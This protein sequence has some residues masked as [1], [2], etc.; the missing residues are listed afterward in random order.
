MPLRLL[1]AAKIEQDASSR[2]CSRRTQFFLIHFLETCDGLSLT[3]HFLSLFL[4]LFISLFLSLFLS[5]SIFRGCSPPSLRQGAKSVM[6]RPQTRD[7]TPSIRHE[8]RAEAVQNFCTEECSFSFPKALV[9]APHAAR[10]AL[11]R[12]LA[13]G[14]STSPVGCFGLF[15]SLK[16]SLPVAL[17]VGEEGEA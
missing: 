2:G 12:V 4:S 9:D 6:P 11:L 3:S 10:P 8:L 7:T 5:V 14:L 17:V 13:Q 1:L 16:G 15:G